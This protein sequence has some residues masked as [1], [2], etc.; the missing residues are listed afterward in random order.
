ML[1][2]PEQSAAYFKGN[3]MSQNLTQPEEIDY[4]LMEMAG[5]DMKAGAPTPD[6]AQL[7]GVIHGFECDEAI[8]VTGFPYGIAHKKSAHGLSDP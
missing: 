7:N 3:I 1:L 4:V 8:G 5:H 6:G 2:L